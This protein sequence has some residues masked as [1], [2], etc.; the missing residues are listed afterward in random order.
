MKAKKSIIILSFALLISI[1]ANIST[2][3]LVGKETA[4]DKIEQTETVEI[5]KELEVRLPDN[6]SKKLV[7]AGMDI[8]MESFMGKFTYTDT[9]TDALYHLN[10][11]GEFLSYINPDVERINPKLVL[12][13]KEL[14]NL[15]EKFAKEYFGERFNGYKYGS[16]IFQDYDGTDSD[17]YY[18]YF[19][20]FYGKNFFIEGELCSV[21]IYNDGSIF[22]CGMT[23]ESDFA[24]FDKTRLDKINK[25]DIEKFA[26]E[27][28]DAL[29]DE[30]YSYE[31][32]DIRLVNKDGEAIILFNCDVSHKSLIA[33]IGDTVS[34][35]YFYY[36]IPK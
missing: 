24:E 16:N 9:Q 28:I 8:E 19:H 32:R 4:T 31:L 23:L 3:A 11:D 18:I 25:Q 15:A 34:S 17:M 7:Y 35:E 6:S 30:Y 21:Y 2:Y 26:K 27:Q 13:E 29:Y 36:E 14:I 1:I 10:E 20:K 22:A 33:E 12:S 5:K